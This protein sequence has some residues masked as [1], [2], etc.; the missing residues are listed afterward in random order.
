MGYYSDVRI[1]TTKKGYKALQNEIEKYIKEKDYLVDNLLKI[2]KV[3]ETDEVV[4]I[5]WQDLK[6]YEQY[7]DVKVI[8]NSL[9][10]IQ[11][12]EYSWTF[13]RIGEDYE[14]IET[15]YNIQ[16]FDLYD[17]LDIPIRREFED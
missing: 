2:A 5:D 17:I 4:T 11:E 3:A 7:E 15:E 6:W 8:T 9:S 13:A 16:D 12:Q 10:K 14:D 1:K